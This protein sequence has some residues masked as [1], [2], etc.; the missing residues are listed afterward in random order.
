MANWSP[1]PCGKSWPDL[2]LSSPLVLFVD[3]Q[4]RELGEFVF[5]TIGDRTWRVSRRCIA[6][7]GITGPQLRSGRSGFQEIRRKDLEAL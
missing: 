4:V 6:Y 1:C 7:H 2:N 3:R 5:V